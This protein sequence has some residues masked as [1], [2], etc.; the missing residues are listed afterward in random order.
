M[1]YDEIELMKLNLTEES[2]KSQI[3]GIR[4]TFTQAKNK[5]TKRI[6][7]IYDYFWIKF[8]I[9]ELQGYTFTISPS[10]LYGSGHVTIQ[11]EL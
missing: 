2:I 8:I 7:L 1:I 9:D 10:P 11:I 3:H 4:K 5:K 6:V